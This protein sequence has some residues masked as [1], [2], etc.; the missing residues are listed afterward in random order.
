[1]GLVHLDPSDGPRADVRSAW[2]G[3]RRDTGVMRVTFTRH[4]DYAIRAMLALAAS[5]PGSWLSVTRISAA[6]DIPERFLPRVMRTLAAAALI[7]A[8]TGR[9]GGYRLTRPAG[10]ITLLEVITAA[11]PSVEART[12]CCAAARAGSMGVVWSMTSSMRPGG[13]SMRALPRPRWRI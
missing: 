9:T 7:E 13:P 3:G 8:R 2:P 11:E 5:E 6:M 1:M 12:A 10:S 4:G